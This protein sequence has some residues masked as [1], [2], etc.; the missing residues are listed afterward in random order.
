MFLLPWLTLV[1]LYY[2]QVYHKNFLALCASGYYDGTIFHRNIKGFMIQGGDP[3]GT[4]KGGTSIWGKK[5]NDEIRESL[6]VRI[7]SFLNTMNYLQLQSPFL[8]HSYP[9]LLDLC[10]FLHPQRIINK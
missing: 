2:L 5:F 9:T 10:H 3:T 7:K 1:S 4:G 8:F 6:K